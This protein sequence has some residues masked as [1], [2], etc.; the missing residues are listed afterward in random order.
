LSFVNEFLSEQDQKKLILY[1]IKKNFCMLTIFLAGSRR[2]S[3]FLPFV[4][5]DEQFKGVR[6]VVSPAAGRERPG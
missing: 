1:G 3:A 6:S 2:F 5:W 4:H